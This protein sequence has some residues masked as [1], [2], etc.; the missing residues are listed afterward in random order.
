MASD[1]HDTGDTTYVLVHVSTGDPPWGRVFLLAL[2]GEMLRLL[3]CVNKS[4]ERCRIQLK[5]SVAAM[6]LSFLAVFVGL[7]HFL[8]FVVFVRLLVVYKHV[9][10]Y[11]NMF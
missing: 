1:I 3:L 6:L 10:R 11:A 4:S 7:L 2:R 9:R 5:G 8:R